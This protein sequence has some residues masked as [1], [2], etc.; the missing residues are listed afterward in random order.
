MKKHLLFFILLFFSISFISCSRRDSSF[1]N[2]PEGTLD[3]ASILKGKVSGML[4]PEH[5]PYRVRGIIEVDSLSTLI[6]EP[7]VS[8]L[9]SDTSGLIVRGK[10]ISEGNRQQP[11][12]FTAEG[13]TWKGIQFVNS[14]KNSIMS[15]SIVEKISITM[16]DIM[17]IGALTLNNSSASIH[18]SIFRDNSSPEGGGIYLLS[19]SGEIKNCIFVNNEALMFGGAV[20]SYDSDLTF[21]NN[22]VYKNSCQ[23]YG[24]GLVLRESRSSQ[25]ENNVFYKNTGRTGIP[26]ITF[27]GDTSKSVIKY[28]FMGYGLNSP[29]FVS[30]NNFHLSQSSPCIDKGNPEVIFNDPDKTRNDQGAYGG[31][32]GEW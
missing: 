12:L 16:N 10:L 1:S 22:T 7:G 5:S 9:F 20:L 2:D 4:I 25:A 29:Q 17:D 13:T 15:F 21:V 24:G 26:D 3:E 8:L 14:K 18:N 30:E 32:L 11:V 6:I 19:S 31:P 28:N 23:N 27:S